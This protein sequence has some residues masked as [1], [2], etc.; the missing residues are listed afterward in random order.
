MNGERAV[1]FSHW[2]DENTEPTPFLTIYRLTG[3]NREIRSQIGERFVLL[4][5]SDAIYA[6]EFH[7][8]EWDCG[9]TKEDLLDRFDLI[10]TEWSTENG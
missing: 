2:I 1:V 8:N 10:E 7:E 6:A 4:V 9:L 3:A 5:E